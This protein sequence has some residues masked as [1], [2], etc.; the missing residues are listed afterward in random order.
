MASYLLIPRRSLITFKFLVSNSNVLHLF[1]NSVPPKCVPVLFV[2]SPSL[3]DRLVH[4]NEKLV[5]AH[6]ILGLELSDDSILFL[7]N[8]QDPPCKRGFLGYSSSDKYSVSCSGKEFLIYLR[9]IHVMLW[10]FHCTRISP[11]LVVSRQR[12]VTVLIAR[13]ASCCLISVPS[14]W[15]STISSKRIWRLPSALTCANRFCAIAF[16][17]IDALW[18]SRY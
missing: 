13:N 18:P 8:E 17:V 5:G 14:V 2:K 9:A 16:E 15:W 6:P 4:T 3:G 12:R 7:D 11:P 10:S 1:T